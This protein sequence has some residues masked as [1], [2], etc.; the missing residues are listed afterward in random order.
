MRAEMIIPTEN[1]EISVV[2]DTQFVLVFEGNG[3]KSV[4]LNLEKEGVQAE[5]LALYRL[6][7]GGHLDLTTVAAHKV[8]HTS[9]NTIIRGVLGDSSE[10]NYVGKIVI[11]RNSQQTTS[12]LDDKVLVVGNGAK[13]TSQPILEIEADDVKASHGATTGGVNQEHVYYLQSRGLSKEEAQN[14]IIEGFFEEVLAKISDEDV[15]QKVKEKMY[16]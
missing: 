8:P 1:T 4:T 12:Y 16:V 9:C 15:K 11:P 14:I 5:L 6:E 2:E 13:N 7:K 3:Q 10:S